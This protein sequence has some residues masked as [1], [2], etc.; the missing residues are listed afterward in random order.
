MFPVGHLSIGL[1]IAY[2]F[3]KKLSLHRISIPLVMF[4]SIAPD[5]DIFFQSA[6]IGSHKSITHSAILCTFFA[7]IVIAKYGKPALIYSLAYLQHIVI[8]DIIVGPIN[9]LY[10][11]GNLLVDLG[12][13]YGSL[14]HIVLELVL[15]SCM[16]AIILYDRRRSCYLFEFAYRRAD[17]FVYC[18]VILSLIVS[19]T[20]IIYEDKYLLLLFKESVI[21]LSSFILSYIIA[22]IAIV[23]LCLHPSHSQ[24]KSRMMLKR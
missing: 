15:S 24:D 10:P 11:F 19:I 13:K 18:V 14:V 4:L 17:L 22:M 16:L 5:V 23:L 1:I 6:G 3:M 9:L 12:I 21:R 2:F 8:G 7:S 20:Y